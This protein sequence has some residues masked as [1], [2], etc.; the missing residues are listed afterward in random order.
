MDSAMTGLWFALVCGAIAVVYGVVSRSWILGLPAGNARMQ[1]IALAIQQGASRLSQS[2]VHD[3][4]DRRRHPVP[5]HRLRSWARLAHGRRLRARRHALR[6]VGLHRHERLGA[7]QRAHGRSGAHAA[8]TRRSTSRSAAAR[9]PACWSSASACSASPASTAFLVGFGSREGADAT[10]EGLHDHIQPLVG[11]AFGGVADLDLRASR[12]RHLHQGRRRRRRPRR[13]GRGRH[14]RGRSA[15]SGGDRG[16]RRRQ[17]RRLRRHG[18]RPV[19][20]L[21]GHDRSRRCCSA[22]CCCRRSPRRPRSSIRWCSAA[23][24]S[25][26]R[27]SAASSSRHTPGSKIM[28]AL[29]TRPDRRRRALGHRVLVHHRAG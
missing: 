14:S 3:D 8:S 1:E 18:R 19:R 2:P 26:R 6:P 10:R 24:R 21:R 29:Y 11:L 17:R 22:R 12:R 4:R 13:Q 28:N 15:Q 9:S 20:D 5:H 25:S 7:R 27:S 23:S 16:Q